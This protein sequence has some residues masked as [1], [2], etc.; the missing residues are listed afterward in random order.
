M[1]S[2]WGLKRGLP[3]GLS[4]GLISTSSGVRGVPSRGLLPVEALALFAA[5]WARVLEEKQ[6]QNQAKKIQDKDQQKTNKK[7]E[8]RK[9]TLPPPRRN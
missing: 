7:Q 2:R 1:N 3:R 9:L 6:Q 8:P 4:S 5:L